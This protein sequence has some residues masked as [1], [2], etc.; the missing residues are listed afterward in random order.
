MTIPLVE[1]QTC[2]IYMYCMYG[3]YTFLY[4]INTF[5]CNVFIYLFLMQLKCKRLTSIVLWYSSFGLDCDSLAT[6]T[7]NSVP[8][9]ALSLI[10][11]D[12]LFLQS[13]LTFGWIHFPLTD[14]LYMG[15]YFRLESSY[16]WVNTVSFCF[17]IIASSIKQMTYFKV[18][19]GSCGLGRWHP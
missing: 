5:L 15:G 19:V 9:L 12:I 10:L 13:H 17:T 11:S 1:I 6:Q 4:S 18:S 7:N 3:I 16:I 14:V 2:S 8:H